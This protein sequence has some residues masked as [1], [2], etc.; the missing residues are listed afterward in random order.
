MFRNS[1]AFSS[2]SVDDLG[3]AR[4][5]YGD[6]LGLNIVE[7]EYLL[8]LHLQGAGHITIYPKEDHIPATYTVLN[9]SVPDILAAVNA[10]KG[11]GIRFESY[12][13]PGLKTGDD[14]IF[15]DEDMHIRIAWFRDPAGNILSVI[16]ES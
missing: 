9:F 10:L 16:E 15:R 6:L 11:K 3:K 13:L 14:H 7:E 1:K 12:D 4:Q 5:F 2:F 8:E